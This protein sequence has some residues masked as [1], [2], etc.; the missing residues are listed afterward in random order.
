MSIY[1]G[2]IFGMNL[3]TDSP[4]WAQQFQKRLCLR[5][6]TTTDK[7]A[8]T[9]AHGTRGPDERKR[10]QQILGLRVEIKAETTNNI[11][12]VKETFPLPVLSK[13]L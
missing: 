8:M 9:I 2:V 11:K 13:S 5:I 6:P 4:S 1:C 12:K 3:L 10:N 7:Q